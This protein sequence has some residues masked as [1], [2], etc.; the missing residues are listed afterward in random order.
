MKFR[1]GPPLKMFMKD[2]SRNSNPS[3]SETNWIMKIVRPMLGPCIT[4]LMELVL[5]S[6][7]K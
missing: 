5:T 4:Y 3:L 2:L 1:W 6:F 7:A